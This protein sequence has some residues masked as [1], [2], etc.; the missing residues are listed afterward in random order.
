MQP[1]DYTIRPANPGPSPIDLGIQ[2]AYALDALRHARQVRVDTA[3]A[4]RQQQEAAAIRRAELEAELVRIDD[5]PSPRALA[6][7][8]LRFPEMVAPIKQAHELLQPEQQRTLIGQSSQVYAALR[9]G[10]ADVA[11]NIV[12]RQIEANR[13]AGDEEE[14]RNLERL[15]E[16]IR[17]D[18]T[19]ATETVGLHLAAIDPKFI[20]SMDK[21]DEGRREADLHPTEKA[22]LE[23][24]AARAGAQA[25]IDAAEADVRPEALRTDIERTRTQIARDRAEIARVQADT[26]RIRAADAVARQQQAA[27]EEYVPPT[28]PAAVPPL[29]AIRY[30]AAA[31][32]TRAV[33]A[34]NINT[35]AEAVGGRLPFERTE[36]A[37]Q[38]IENLRVQTITMAQDAIPGRPSNYLM[39]QLDRLAVQPGSIFMGQDRARIRLIQTRN[40]LLQEAN[41]VER[42]ILR[43]PE[44]FSPSVLARSRNSFGMIQQL[45]QQY[46][47]V[48]D[49][50]P[51]ARARSAT[52]APAPALPPGFV[53]DR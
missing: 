4:N 13:N 48:I 29:D 17:A 37:L 33:I 38:A 52:P 20:E 8:A 27:V 43:Q 47:Q 44:K 6:R 49:A 34:R 39:Q 2:D 40:M 16:V 46:N 3:E 21:I 23:A 31:F 11:Q 30:P 45:V 14:A 19:L 41:R 12:T 18:P 26:N 5:N 9:T 51:G 22:K 50:F 36:E 10:R 42:E 53:V 1:M 35:L 32:G 24:E 15:L 25:R 7:L 28:V